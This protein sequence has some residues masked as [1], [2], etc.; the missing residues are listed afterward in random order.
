MSYVKKEPISRDNKKILL[1]IAAKYE[2]LENNLH[3]HVEAVRRKWQSWWDNWLYIG[4]KLSW[5]STCTLFQNKVHIDDLRGEYEQWN[6]WRPR[7]I[8]V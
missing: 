6:F 1:T 7:R 4:K 2:T 3:K 5:L 8:Y